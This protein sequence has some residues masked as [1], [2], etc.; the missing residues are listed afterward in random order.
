[1]Q[2]TCPGKKPP[3][4]SKSPLQAS[5]APAVSVKSF[6][7]QRPQ[8]CS[9]FVH[10]GCSPAE[11][12]PA[13]VCQGQR[14]SL[15]PQDSAS[16]YPES[17]AASGPIRDPLNSRAAEPDEEGHC[18]SYSQG[19]SFPQGWQSPRIGGQKAQPSSKGVLLNGP[20]VLSREEG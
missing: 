18:L 9:A 12:L 8:R 7:S 13:H 2:E 3:T 11:M 1:M 6:H 5:T 20:C 15:H 16:K 10:L 14:Q 4:V 19:L 17:F